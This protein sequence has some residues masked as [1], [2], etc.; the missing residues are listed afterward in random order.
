VN[1]APD[2][3]PDSGRLHREQHR[4]QPGR[5]AAAKDAR[6]RVYRLAGDGDLGSLA[7]ADAGPA[8]GAD[9]KHQEGGGR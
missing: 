7:A 2:P 9:S 6:R 4:L 5:A 8:E 1:R 3:Q